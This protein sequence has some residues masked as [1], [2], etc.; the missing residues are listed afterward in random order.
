MAEIWEDMK[1]SQLPSWI[2]P[3]PPNWGTAERGKLS[4]DQWR[5]ICTIHLPITLIRL[6][7][8]DTGRMYDLLRHFMHLVTAVRI[9]NM[10]ISLPNHIRTYNQHIFAYARGWDTLF[11]DEPLKPNLHAALHIGNMLDKFGPVHAI[12]S[13]FYERYINFFHQLKTNR[14]I[15]TY[16]CFD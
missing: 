4:A 9:A 3:P 5:V 7:G 1:R 6:W 13:P 15:G 2:Q 10:R 14:K 16:R 8:N 11:P 12:S